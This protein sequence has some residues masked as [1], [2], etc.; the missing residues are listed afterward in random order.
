LRISVFTMNILDEGIYLVW[1]GGCRTP[2]HEECPKYH[3]HKGDP[4]G[5]P[6]ICGAVGE[7]SGRWEHIPPTKNKSHKGVDFRMLKKNLIKYVS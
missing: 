2:L 6:K 4:G 7:G 3:G 5:T 1:W